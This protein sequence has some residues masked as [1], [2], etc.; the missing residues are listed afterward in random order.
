MSERPKVLVV[1]GSE[2]DLGVV[3]KGLETLSRLGVPFEVRVASAHRT[4]ARATE[5]ARTAAERGFRVIVAAAGRAAHLA[6]V[7]AAHTDLPVIGLPVASGALQG[8][9]ALLS[10]VQMPSG[11]PVATVGI[12]GAVNAALLAARIVALADPAL[13][14]ALAEIREHRAQAVQEADERIRAEFGGG[15]GEGQ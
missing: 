11:T 5:L 15:A 10:T 8:V 1:M 7:L 12:D 4:P 6:G 13:S 9:D 14:E 2:S 3:R